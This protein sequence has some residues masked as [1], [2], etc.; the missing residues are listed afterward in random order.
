VVMCEGPLIRAKDLKLGAGAGASTLGSLA[1]A[2]SGVER[3]IVEAALRRNDYNVAA[4]ARELSV[5]RVTLY[6][7]L[8]RLGLAPKRQDK[9]VDSVVVQMGAVRREKYDG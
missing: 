4:T 7:L 6:R 1:T 5:S 8:R 2:R 3:D 9:R